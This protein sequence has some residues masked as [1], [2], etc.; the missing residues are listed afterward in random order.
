MWN[1]GSPSHWLAP[2]SFF[3]FDATVNGL[4]AMRCCAVTTFVRGLMLWDILWYYFIWDPFH[5]MLLFLFSCFF[6]FS[7]R[8]KSARSI[9]IPSPIEA[10]ECHNQSPRQGD[11]I[12]TKI[13]ISL[14]PEQ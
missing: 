2:G 10:F 9:S 12:S 1:V 13:S 6:Q 4:R 14:S 11:P 7:Q 5:W 3:F 8:A